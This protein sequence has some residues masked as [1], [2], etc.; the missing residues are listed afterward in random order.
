M[1]EQDGV[2]TARNT[3][4]VSPGRLDR[5]PCGTGTSARLA[6]MHARGE[7][8]IGEKFVHESIIGSRLT[9]EVF[10][11]LTIGGM[12]GIRPSITGSAWITAFHNYVLDPSDPFPTGFLLPDA[13]PSTSA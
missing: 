12:P 13:W 8:A 11:E 1:R 9:G 2:K 3:V 5:S 10:E 7:I 6:I 4:V